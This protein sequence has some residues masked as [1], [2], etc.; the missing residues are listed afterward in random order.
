MNRPD[1]ER[2]ISWLPEIFT[3]LRGSRYRR[4]GHDMVWPG[5]LALNVQRG[6][7]YDFSTS[8]NTTHPIEAIRLADPERRYDSNA[9]EAWAR[10]WL[11]IHPGFG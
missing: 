9:A 11:A 4:E 1:R 8:E 6:W 2:L 10:Q 7:V 5:G 3:E